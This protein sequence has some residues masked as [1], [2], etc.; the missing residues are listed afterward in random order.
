V[1]LDA[2]F[3]SV[4]D[5]AACAAYERLGL[6]LS[7]ESGGARSLHVGLGPRRFAV[8]FLAA[9][10]WPF[11]A[12]PL[13]K[14]RAD[15]RGLFAFGVR[16]PCQEAHWLGVAERA[17]VDLVM[18]PDGPMVAGA[19]VHDFPLARADHVAV[20]AH[21]LEEKTRFWSAALSVPLA[22]E[23]RTPR[24]IIRQLRLGDVTL[25]LLA[26]ASPDSP[27]ASRPAGPSSLISWEVPD[28]DAA[29]AQARRAGFTVPDAD[30]GPLP[31]SRIATIPAA[32]LAGVAMQLIQ[33][34]A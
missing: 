6:T 13:A 23:V 24:L 16:S 21:D 2:A 25:E 15:G 10:S 8:H 17:G 26:A 20:V 28:V 11:L 1:I 29:V 4:P 19:P 27:I 34:V 9:S 22:G 30:A 7:P 3:V 5:L 14:A 18:Q 31:G 33:W 12:E 32:E